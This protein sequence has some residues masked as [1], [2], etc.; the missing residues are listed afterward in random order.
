MRT[1]HVFSLLMLSV[2]AALLIA[3]TMVGV[4]TSATQTAHVGALRGGVLRVADSG[5]G[6]DTLDP[7][8]AYVANDWAVLYATQR[9]LLNFPTKAGKAGSVLQPD[10]AAAMPTIS[11]DGRTYTF[12][13]RRGM[14]FSDGSPVTAASFQRAFERVLSPQMYVQNGCFIGLDWMIVGAEKFANCA[15]YK[16][17]RRSPHISG[18]RAEGLT[19]IIR[20]TKPN[21]TFLS[22]VGMQWFG[23]IEPSMKYSINPNGVLTYPS[24]GPYYLKIDSPQRLAVLVRN[25]YYD[26]FQEANPNEI[27]INENRGSGEAQLLQIEKGQLDYDMAGV[28]SDQVASVSSRYGGPNKSQF[29]VGPT[30]CAT[31]EALNNAKPPTNDVRV[32]RALNYAIGRTQ[33]VKLFGL[34]A[35]SASDQILIP[36][37]AGYKKVTV[38]GN[39]PNVGK[40][41]EVGGSALANAVPLN[42]YANSTNALGTNVAEL[43]QAQLQH[44]G[45]TANLVPPPQGPFI[46]YDRSYNLAPSGWCADHFDPFDFMNL[47]FDSRLNAQFSRGIHFSDSSFNAKAE[48]AASL[49]GPARARAYAALDRL[50]IT[51]YAP[52]IPLDVANFRYLTSKRVR[53]VIYSNYYGGPALNALSVG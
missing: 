17:A 52:V 4:A 14:R 40:A 53:N 48:H 27:V 39:Y 13:L 51:K 20:L 9:L 33:I 5:G 28:P 47:L 8:L 1:K 11:K 34:Y 2:G 23:A 50:L 12:H 36:G 37:M 42:I 25:K 16:N 45:L 44:I 24:A 10:A 41:K 18:I 19:L 6:L 15:G 26:G 7:Q 46:D 21:P 3:V 29:H 35:G 43:I 49:H 38:Y 22:I 31:W 30:T 32:R